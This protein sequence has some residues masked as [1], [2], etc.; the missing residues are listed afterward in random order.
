MSLKKSRCIK[1]YLFSAFAILNS[2]GGST[3][4]IPANKEATPNGSVV[5]QGSFSGIGDNQ[6]SGAVF[7]FQN[8]NQHNL[9]IEGLSVPNQNGLLVVVKADGEN[10]LFTDLRSKSGDQ[11]YPLDVGVNTNWTSVEI[12]TFQETVIGIAVLNSRQ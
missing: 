9:R 2:C 12:L 6:V 5:A 11:N 3:G 4:T 7:I 8:G 10:V 1:F